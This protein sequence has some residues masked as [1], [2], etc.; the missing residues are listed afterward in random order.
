MNRSGARLRLRKHRT[1][2]ISIHS[3]ENGPV[4]FEG[5]E[6]DHKMKKPPIPIKTVQDLPNFVKCTIGIGTTFCR[7]PGFK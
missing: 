4:S 1:N 5:G 2:T 7:E 3:L 6:P